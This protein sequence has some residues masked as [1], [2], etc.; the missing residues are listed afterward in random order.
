MFTPF[1]ASSNNSLFSHVKA[2]PSFSFNDNSFNFFTESFNSQ[3]PP[4]GSLKQA[5]VL[6]QELCSPF[7]SNSDINSPLP[8]PGFLSPSNSI[9]GLPDLS[10]ASANWSQSFLD[11]H[12]G[13]PINFINQ[14]T[15]LRQRFSGGGYTASSEGTM[16]ALENIQ[17]FM[18]SWR[19]RRSHRMMEALFARWVMEVYRAKGRPVEENISTFPDETGP[20]LSWGAGV[21]LNSSRPTSVKQKLV[22]FSD[23]HN[24]DGSMSVHFLVPKGLQPDVNRECRFSRRNIRHDRVPT[25]VDHHLCTW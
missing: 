3:L 22:A 11:C 19:R 21:P 23:S 6:Q 8:I 7:H 25:V 1:D 13:A 16:V 14:N 15:I 12:T 17:A 9:A 5:Q 20:C 2:E 10:P 4:K 18:L 24:F